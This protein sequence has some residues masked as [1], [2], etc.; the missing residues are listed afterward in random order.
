MKKIVHR[1]PLDCKQNLTMFYELTC[2]IQESCSFYILFSQPTLIV[3][4]LLPVTK[5]SRLSK[6]PSTSW[7]LDAYTYTVG[8]HTCLPVIAASFGKEVNFKTYLHGVSD[9]GTRLLFKFWSGTHGLIEELGRHRGRNGRT[10]C[11]FVWR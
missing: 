5:L 10:K 6:Y 4:F 2:C 9:A 1:Y 7:H 11:V 8:T 3:L